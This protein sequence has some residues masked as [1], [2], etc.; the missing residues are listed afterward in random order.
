MR[1]HS[2]MLLFAALLWLAGP[3]FVY[4][5]PVTGGIYGKHPSLTDLDQGDLKMIVDF[6]RVYS[7]V[8]QD[9]LGV[10]PGKA[11]RGD[12]E[13]LPLFRA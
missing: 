1:N 5:T 2:A 12:W 13:P 7:T 9:W 8:L 10:D 3:M 4:G 6:R 11:L